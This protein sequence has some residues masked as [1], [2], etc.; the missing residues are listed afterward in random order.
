MRAA[1]SS[2]SDPFKNKD[3][4]PYKPSK[5]STSVKKSMHIRFNSD[6]DDAPEPIVEDDD[7]EIDNDG[8]NLGL[9][10]GSN[11]DVS[12]DSD[13]SNDDDAPEVLSMAAS[14]RDVVEKEKARKEFEKAAALAKRQA[15]RARDEK[16]KQSKAQ[17]KSRSKHPEPPSSSSSSCEESDTEP[18]SSLPQAS[19]ANKK[20]LDPSLFVSASNFL[21][22]SKQDAQALE[23]TRVSSVKKKRKRSQR[24]KEQDHREIGDNTFVV[25]LSK[26]NHLVPSTR[27]EA[28]SNFVRNRL[29]YNKSR[30]SPLSLPKITLQA[31]ASLGSR[32]RTA[33]ASGSRKQHRP[34]A[35]FAR[36]TN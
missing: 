36:P 3:P 11:E 9:R 31:K 5:P 1:S 17:A 26:P 12:S 4:K 35:L 29:S 7:D 34:A 28:V 18:T 14:K 19:A 30:R 8:S 20:Y 25:R 16:L 2:K 22:K 10:L 33:I 23:E 15:N 24:A 21:E 32:S 27:P 6:Q 13:E